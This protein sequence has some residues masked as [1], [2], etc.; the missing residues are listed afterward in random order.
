MASTSGSGSSCAGLKRPNQSSASAATPTPSSNVAAAITP[1][2]SAAVARTPSSNAAAATTKSTDEGTDHVIL[3]EEDDNV[4]V[5]VK[6]KSSNQM[7]G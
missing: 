6:K 3:V 4:H 1:F 5:G 2:S 7:C